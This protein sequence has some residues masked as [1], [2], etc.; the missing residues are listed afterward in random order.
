MTNFADDRAS[1]I[2]A[3]ETNEHKEIGI[4]NTIALS[5]SLTT[6][7]LS[8]NSKRT[9]SPKN[10][11]DVGIASMFSAHAMC[12]GNQFVKLTQA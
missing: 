4:Q 8:K 9:T 6:T 1:V 2:F 12:R 7:Q 10:R 3:Q 5:S 11:M